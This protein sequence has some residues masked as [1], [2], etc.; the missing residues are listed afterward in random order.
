MKFFGGLL[1]VQNGKQIGEIITV[2][3]FGN[4]LLQYKVFEHSE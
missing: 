3:S 1:Y 4:I 2:K